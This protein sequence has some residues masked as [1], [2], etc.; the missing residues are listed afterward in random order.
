MGKMYQIQWNLKPLLIPEPQGVVNENCG[1][2][3]AQKGQNELGQLFQVCR[4]KHVVSRQI[5]SKS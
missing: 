2:K 4:S 5:F 3:Y 1:I